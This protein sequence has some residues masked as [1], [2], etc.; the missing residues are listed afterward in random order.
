[1]PP[2][3]PSAVRVLVVD[4]EP[5]MCKLV[6]MILEQAGYR[7]RTAESAAAAIAIVTTEGPPDLLLTDLKMPQMDGDELAGHLRRL[8]PD[9]KVLYL[10]GFSQALFDSR[11]LLWAGEAFLEKPATSAAVLEAV[12]LL[13]FDRVTPTPGAGPKGVG[14]VV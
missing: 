12:S 1:M 14:D 3:T 9:L 10:T 5:Q 8:T 7:V 13:L 6:R 11:R 4:D 2:R